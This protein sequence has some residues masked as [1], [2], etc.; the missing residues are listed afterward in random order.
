P[1]RVRHFQICLPRR[2]SCFGEHHC[3]KD[4]SPSLGLSPLTLWGKPAPG[5]ALFS[6]SFSRVRTRTTCEIASG[7]ANE[8]TPT[9]Q[10]AATKTN[11]QKSTEI[12]TT[13]AAVT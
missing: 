10:T 13:K 11:G 3:E 6:V 12:Q 8:L 4:F 2:R 1:S 9:I 5:F 7:L